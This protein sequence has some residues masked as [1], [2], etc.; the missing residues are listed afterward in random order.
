[1]AD[2]VYGGPA[3]ACK[4]DCDLTP[5]AAPPVPRNPAAPHRPAPHGLNHPGLVRHPL[6]TP[7]VQVRLLQAADAEAGVTLGDLVAAIP[8]HPRPVAAILA[9]IE[10]GWLMEE[11]RAPFDANLRIWRT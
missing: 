9:L 3:P 6:I 11:L 2:A 5:V 4:C 7:D 8:D 10:A 1:M